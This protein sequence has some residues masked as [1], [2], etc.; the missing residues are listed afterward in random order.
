MAR[1]RA[2]ATPRRSPRIKRIQNQ[3]SQ[4]LANGEYQLQKSSFLLYLST[5]SS[6]QKWKCVKQRKKKQTQ[7][8]TDWLG[9]RGSQS[10]QFDSSKDHSCRKTS[11]KTRFIKT[12][13]QR[14]SWSTPNWGGRLNQLW[15]FTKTN[16]IWNQFFIRVSYFLEQTMREQM[17][18]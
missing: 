11:F 1:T 10:G 6:R 12:I 16:V 15:C 4:Q 13:L 14:I 18:Q 7:W 5:L 3:R 8:T 9:S 17:L 2:Q